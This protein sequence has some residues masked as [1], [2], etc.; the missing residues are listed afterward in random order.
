M[1][2]SPAQAPGSPEGARAPGK[3][4][5]HESAPA[6]PREKQPGVPKTQS[7]EKPLIPVDAL[8]AEKKTPLSSAPTQKPAPVSAATVDPLIDTKAD[9][10]PEQKANMPNAAVAAPPATSDLAESANKPNAAVDAGKTP[11]RSQDIEDLLAQ[12]KQVRS[13]V[14]ASS[15]S[16]EGLL[17]SSR[18]VSLVDNVLTLGFASE[19]LRSKMENKENLEVTASAIEQVTGNAYHIRCVVHGSRNH[20]NPADHQVDTDGVVGVALNLGGKIVHKD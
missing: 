19:I 3:P 15:M 7:A 13:V 10:Q 2:E 1:L 5:Q 12:W 20:Q 18:L 14:K 8:P 9:R 17:N 11:G 4:L 16:T 6:H